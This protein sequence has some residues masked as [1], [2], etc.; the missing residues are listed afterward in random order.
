MKIIYT[1]DAPKPNGHYSQAI[2][3]D[4]IIYVSGQLPM[5]PK[6]EKRLPEKPEEQTRRALSNLD[7]ILKSAGSSKEKVLKIVI[8]ISNID[9]WDSV[10]IAFEEYFGDHK[11]ART[12]VPTRDLHFD[13]LIELDAVAFMD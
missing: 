13:F 7:A 9:M 12:I 1:D 11:P 4:N 6:I 5:N 8:Y 2:I 10:N 3:H